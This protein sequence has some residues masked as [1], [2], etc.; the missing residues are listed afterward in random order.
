MIALP[1]PKSAPIRNLASRLFFFPVQRLN[2]AVGRKSRAWLPRAKS[3][4]GR[5]PGKM[6]LR[7]RVV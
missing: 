7:L 5:D 3:L 2:S 1:D 6:H 4:A